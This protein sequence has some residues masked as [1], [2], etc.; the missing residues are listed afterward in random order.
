[1]P[2]TVDGLKNIIMNDK[3]INQMTLGTKSD[4]GFDSNIYV[5]CNNSIPSSEQYNLLYDRYK[6]IFQT[7]QNP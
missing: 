1:M 2:R 4:Y 6:T 7:I 5:M 3:P